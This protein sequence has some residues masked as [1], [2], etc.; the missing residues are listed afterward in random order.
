MGG[1]ENQGAAHPSAAPLPFPREN[2]GT[3]Q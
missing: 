2:A 1:A 3:D